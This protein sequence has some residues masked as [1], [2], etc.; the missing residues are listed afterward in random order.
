MSNLACNEL[1]CRTYVLLWLWIVFKMLIVAE[2]KSKTM[3][4]D[5]SSWSESNHAIGNFPGRPEGG[6]LHLCDLNPLV[7]FRGD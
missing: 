4:G 3:H 1:K 7:A 6:K 2:L 5:C